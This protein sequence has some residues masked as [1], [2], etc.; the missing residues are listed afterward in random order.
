MIGL[1]V[2]S[3]LLLLLFNDLRLLIALWMLLIALLGFEWAHLDCLALGVPEVIRLIVVVVV[4]AIVVFKVGHAFD[5]EGGAA[6]L[7]GA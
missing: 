6:I 4:V 7:N 5:E 1:I 2:Y 3:L